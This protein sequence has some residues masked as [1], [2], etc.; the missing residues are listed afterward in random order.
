MKITIESTDKS[1]RGAKARRSI[2]RM[3]WPFQPEGIRA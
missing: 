1:D 3:N 2:R